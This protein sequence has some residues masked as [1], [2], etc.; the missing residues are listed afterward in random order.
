MDK[1]VLG[2]FGKGWLWGKEDKTTNNQTSYN[3]TSYDYSVPTTNNSN[4]STTY[5]DNSTNNIEVIMPE[6][7]GNLE[8][9]AKTLAEEVAKYFSTKKQSSGR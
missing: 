1:V 7:T 2:F 5:E 9:D 8:Y 6:T 4:T 3:D